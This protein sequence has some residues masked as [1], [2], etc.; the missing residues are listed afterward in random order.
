MA[1]HPTSLSWTQEQDEKLR[2]LIASGTS[3]LRA[4]AA[5]KRGTSSVRIRA[6]KLGVPFPTVREVRRKI[7]EAQPVR[8]KND[9]S[10]KW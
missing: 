2:A 7:A 5:L 8:D 1:S 4:A 10:P 6:R 3:A 9:M